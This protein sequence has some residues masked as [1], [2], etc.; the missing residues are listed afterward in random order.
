VGDQDRRRAGARH[1][2]RAAVLLGPG[3]I[4]VEDRPMP[5]PGAG[6]VLVEVGA[7][8]VCGS[9]VHYFE[10]GRIG[11]FVVETP[12]VLGH[13][14]AGTI[15]E[16]GPGSRRAVG[17]KVAIEPGR[18]CGACAECRSGSYNLCGDVRFF[19]TPPVDGAFARY[20]VVHDS[21]TFV[22]PDIVS[23]EAA[24][25]AEPLSV[26][27]WACGKARAGLGSRVLVTGAGSIGLCVLMVAQ[28]SG[29]AHITVVDP[30]ASRRER[31]VKLGAEVADPSEAVTTGPFDVFIE[32]S[33]SEEAVHWG[34]QLLGPRGVAVMVGMGPDVVGVPLP[35]VQRR[36][37]TVT[38]TFRYA[39]TYP[40][41]VGLL[42]SGKVDPT[43]LVD[44]RFSLEEVEAAL[45]ATAGDPNMVKAMVLPG[46]GLPGP[47]G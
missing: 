35:V 24:A 25:L 19:G 20:V 5:E 6:E 15:V 41:A 16:T 27:I 40:D 10:H 17:Q 23:L 31:A 3:S 21:Q 45:R 42:A 36:E 26:G 18:S 32:C 22:L 1:P 37:I 13:E 43:G 39:G 33:G 9:D 47:T 7:V 46:A 8:G 38:G 44:A 2:N 34:I 28:A 14:S 11:S 12:L 29:A 30:L 4:V